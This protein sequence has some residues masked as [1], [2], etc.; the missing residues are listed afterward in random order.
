MPKSAIRGL[1]EVNLWVKDPAKMRAFYVDVLGLT[2]IH[3]SGRHIFLKVADGFEGHPQAVALFN[4]R[5][6]G[7]RVKPD[8]TKTTLNH[9]AFSIPLKEFTPEK[10]RLEKLGLDVQVELHREPHWRSMYFH[11]PEGNQVELVAFD[12]TVA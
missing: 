1:G 6:K 10:K 12:K 11:D 2:P 8:I 9:L 5:F 4:S 3:E 7:V